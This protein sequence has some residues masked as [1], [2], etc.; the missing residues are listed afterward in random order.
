MTHLNGWAGS[1]LTVDLTDGATIVRDTMPYAAEYVGGRGIAARLAWET[2]SPGTTPCAP[3]NR[4]IIFTGPLTGTI[5]PTSGR[6]VFMSVSPRVYPRP[7]VTHSTMGG[8]FGSELKYA[9]LDGLVVSGRS[10][11]AVYLSIDDGDARLLDASEL[12]GSGTLETEVW[13]K[14]RHG[15][16]AQVISIGPAGENLV[17]V[18]S[19]QHDEECASGHSGFGAVM[20]AKRLKA[21]V[22]RGTGGIGIARPAEL[23]SEV[24][25]TREIGWISPMHAFDAED[26]PNAHPGRRKSTGPVCSQACTV[27]CHVTRVHRLEGHPDKITTC[28]GG[29]YVGAGEGAPYQHS[30]YAS[31]TLSTP[32]G[33]RFGL[34]DG[35]EVHS[36][37]NSLGLD[38]WLLVTLQPWFLKC[39]EEGVTTIRGEP[40]HPKEPDWFMGIL[41]GLARRQA[42]G[43]LFSDGLRRAADE[44]EDDLPS[45]LIETA[46]SLEFA[47]GF[48]AHREGRLW[49]PE[50][51][52]F[53]AVSMLMYASESRDPAIGT[54]SSCLGLADLYLK[55]GAEARKK[56]RRLSKQLWGNDQ[57]LEPN[58]EHVAQ[59][60]AWTQNQHIVIDSL[61]LCDFVFP[62]VVGGFRSEDEWLASP[63]TSPDLELGA[64]LLSAC[65]GVDYTNRKL[66]VIGERIFDLERAMLAE[67][68]RDRQVDTSIEAHFEL[69][70]KTDGTRVDETL[71]D[72]LIE[73][74]YDHRGWDL[75][76]GW[77]T[78]AKLEELGMVDVADRL[79][80]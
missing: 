54:H 63:D 45:G 8:W 66:E 48:P 64:R 2:I 60:A 80:V 61:P 24:K 5:A 59:V 4:L 67:F 70:C 47:F 52:P 35:I 56:Y 16:D 32:A 29:L 71:F 36:S 75:E 22:V 37:A 10:Q 34:E 39:L 68:G 11:S 7:W 1:F 38:L 19:I 21:I 18:A 15:V 78:R 69:P 3:E 6:T 55:Y 17:R 28:I 13:L 58:F 79:G 26:T 74:Y 25:R 31:A 44:L 27:D 41:D 51:L 76:K 43:G 23:L 42:L 14:N 57:A 65:T 50:P 73:S 12:W 40:L 53:W 62:R 49:D 20:G 72:E 46:R 33:W 9:G 77:P 30:E